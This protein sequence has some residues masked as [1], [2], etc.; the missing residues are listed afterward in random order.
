MTA[1]TR[2]N[3]GIVLGLLLGLCPILIPFVRITAIQRG[4]EALDR[5]EVSTPAIEA[6]FQILRTSIILGTLGFVIFLISCIVLHHAKKQL[7][8]HPSPTKA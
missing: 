4:I 6:V 3:V 8:S 7:A 1:R 2:A 5:G